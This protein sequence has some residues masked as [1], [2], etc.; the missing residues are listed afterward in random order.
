MG[1]ALLGVALAAAC[2]TPDAA[3]G[4]D[5]SC[6]PLATTPAAPIALGTVLGIGRDDADG[7]VYVMDEVSTGYRVFVSDGAGNLA[8]KLI[9]GSGSGGQ[10]TAAWYVVTVSDPTSPFMLKVDGTSGAMRIGI[11]HGVASERDFTVGQTGDLLT[12]EDAAA[13]AGMTALDLPG[14]VTLEYWATLP[15]GRT[16]VVSRPEQNWSYSDFRLF[17]GTPDRMLEH[18]VSSVVRARDGGTTTIGFTVDGGAATAFFPSPLADD[19][20]ATLT[21]DGATL[22]LTVVDLAVAD[23][24]TSPADF[25]YLCLSR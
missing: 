12:V 5:V 8:R 2:G 17:L 11:V 13:I 3:D 15:D 4:G 16:L 18:P 25:A 24:V 19:A 14:T 21:L 7:T 23:P 10:G 6:A 22:P 1:A 20:T 9:T